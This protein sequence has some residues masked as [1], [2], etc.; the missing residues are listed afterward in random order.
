[1]RHAGADNPKGHY[2]NAGRAFMVDSSMVMVANKG[3]SPTKLR[4]CANGREMAACED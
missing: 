4:T 1:M 2:A 3:I